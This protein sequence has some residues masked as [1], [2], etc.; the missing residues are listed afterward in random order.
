MFVMF[1]HAVVQMR[2]LKAAT[3]SI[4]SFRPDGKSPAMLQSII[5]HALIVRGQCVIAL[6]ELNGSRAVR[7]VS[8]ELLHDAC[9][10][11][12][13]QA[14]SRFRKHA[15]LK[16]RIKN[17]P[18]QD[19]SFH[20]T[21]ARAAAIAALWAELPLVGRDDGT[22]GPF[23]FGMDV[24]TVTLANFRQMLA[25]ARS[26]NEAI[27]TQDQ[28]FQQAEGAVRLSLAEMQDIVGAGFTQGRS[29]FPHGTQPR[30]VI[31]GIPHASPKKAA[32]AGKRN[33]PRSP[34]P[35]PS[36]EAPP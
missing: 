11:F 18:N 34:A 13:G 16:G 7:R 26:A 36:E 15:T 29:Q 22:M 32:G 28:A 3:E 4:P 12:A 27:A 35:L 10:A 25:D 2:Y 1:D 17:L 20:Q 31:E 24:V 33:A 30:E 5:D 19:M 21:L 23:T 14:G 6:D 9:V 8:I